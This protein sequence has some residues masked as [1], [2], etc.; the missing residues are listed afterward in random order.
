MGDVNVQKGVWDSAKSLQKYIIL[1]ALASKLG[2][3]MYPI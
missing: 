2:M 3:T 1:Q